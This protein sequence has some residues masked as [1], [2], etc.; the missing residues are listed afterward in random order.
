M[1]TT[2][3]ELWIAWLAAAILAGCGGGGV[4]TVGGTASG[5]LAGTAV[6]LVN[7]GK[8]SLAVA[9]NGPFTFAPDYSAGAS[10]NVTVSMQPAGLA[11]T[12]TDGQDCHA[13]KQ[14]R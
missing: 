6:T 7:N 8:D 3:H 2:R 11:C 1:D 5:L 4:T 14:R 12:V 13:A 9:A 10:Y